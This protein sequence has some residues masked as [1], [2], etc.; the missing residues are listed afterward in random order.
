MNSGFKL[1]YWRSDGTIAR[2]ADAAAQ[3]IDETHVHCVLLA[4]QR[5]PRD[6]GHMARTIEYWPARRA[7][8]NRVEGEFGNRTADYTLWNEIGTRRMPARPFLRPAM[9]AEYPK[10]GQRMRARLQ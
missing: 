5:A 3:A 2:V 10:I 8:R 9:E 1:E 7:G 6:T 4:Q